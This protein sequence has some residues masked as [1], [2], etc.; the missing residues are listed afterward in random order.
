MRETEKLISNKV[1]EKEDEIYLIMH[2]DS[3]IRHYK[4]E[5]YIAVYMNL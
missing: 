1:E 3:Y 4:S 5:S 2:E